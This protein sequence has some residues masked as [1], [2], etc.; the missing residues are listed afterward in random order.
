MKNKD[1][2]S[3]LQRQAKEQ[4][5]LHEERLL[6]KNVDWLTSMIGNYPWQFILVLSVIGALVWQVFF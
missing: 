6:P 5:R 3:V 4:S 1:F 2:V